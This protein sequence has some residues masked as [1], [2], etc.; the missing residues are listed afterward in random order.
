MTTPMEP[1]A[2][3][4][5]FAGSW[6]LDPSRTSIAFHT[7][8]L[9]LLPVTG[10]FQAVQGTGTV[11]DDG[12]ITGTLVVDATSVNTKNSKRDAHLRAADFFDVQTYPAI[13]F[14]ATEARHAASEHIHLDGDLTVHGQTRPLTVAAHI[15]AT[16]C[17]ATVTANLHLDRSNWGLTYTK[18]GSRLATRIVIDAHFVKS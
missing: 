18:K 14:T 3:L 7:K 12:S 8:A 1:A 9:W 17:T 4:S 13:T 11:S 16:D 2:N 5:A 15:V 6:T 10:T